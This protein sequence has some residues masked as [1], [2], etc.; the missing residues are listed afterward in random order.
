MSGKKGR[1]QLNA[2]EPKSW[3][4]NISFNLSKL[5]SSKLSNS[6]KEEDLEVYLDDLAGFHR[7]VLM[8]NQTQPLLFLYT[9]MSF[10]FRFN[11][12]VREVI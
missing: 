3:N 5:Q 11:H 7:W 9:Q 1:V 6:A 8:D 10:N 4:V 12:L 2:A